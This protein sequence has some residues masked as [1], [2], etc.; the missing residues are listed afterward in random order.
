MK[1]DIFKNVVAGFKGDCSH[2]TLQE[3]RPEERGPLLHNMWLNHAKVIKA[4]APQL[5]SKSAIA[6]KFEY[7]L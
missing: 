6:F 3:C 4:T 5:L 7:I 1:H 2:Q